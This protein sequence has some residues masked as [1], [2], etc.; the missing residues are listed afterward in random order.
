[1]TAHG[2]VLLGNRLQVLLLIRS[3][4]AIFFMDWLQKVVLLGPEV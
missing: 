4:V 3:E 2:T 1:M